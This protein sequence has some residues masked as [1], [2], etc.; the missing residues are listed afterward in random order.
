VW[1]K[2]N[3]QPITPRD[4]PGADP[5]AQ[6][7]GG[8]VPGIGVPRTSL[9]ER[10]TFIVRWA[11]ALPIRHAKALYKQRDEKLDAAKLNELIGVAGDDY[12]LEIYGVPAEVA[13]KGTGSV[14]MVVKQSAYLRTKSGRTI[15]PTLVEASLHSLTMTIMVHFPRSSALTL[16]DQEVECYADLQIF[17]FR[18]KFKLSS[19]VYQNHLEL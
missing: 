9:P 12:I 17:D 18:E 11:S 19:M 4:I 3:E 13:H 1:Q 7:I 15:R 8:P 5:N 16:A 14:E 10:A 2:K 6:K